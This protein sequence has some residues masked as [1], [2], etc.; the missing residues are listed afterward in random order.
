VEELGLLNRDEL[1]PVISSPHKL[2]FG[3][4][5]TVCTLRRW[6][7]FRQTTWLSERWKTRVIQRGCRGLSTETKETTKRFPWTW[8]GSLAFGIFV[9]YE[10]RKFIKSGKVSSTVEAKAIPKDTNRDDSGSPPRS[11]TFNFI[12]DAVEIAAPAVVNIEA[13]GRHAGFV[14]RG[15]VGPTSAGSGFIVTEDGMVLTNAHVVENAVKVSVR[16][17][18]G[19]EFSGTV[20]DIDLENDLAAIKL[21]SDK[22]S[23]CLGPGRGRVEFCPPPPPVNFGNMKA[24]TTRLKG[25]KVRPKMFP[26][27]SAT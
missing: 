4:M 14:F 7:L 19:R 16:L 20:I 5:A 12:A 24:V 27:G 2:S 23:L 1:V 25:Q 15:H 9:G 21:D 17:K 10:L 11:A 18:D 22:V 8:I 6:R 26:F 3:K 13:T